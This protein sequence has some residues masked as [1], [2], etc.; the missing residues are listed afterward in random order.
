MGSIAAAC[1]TASQALGL[2]I[3][4]LTLAI[5]VEKIW[6]YDTLG[7]QIAS[8]GTAPDSASLVDLQLGLRKK[9]HYNRI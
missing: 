2:A 1:A 7:Q 5:A 3:V 4:V 8:L 6:K 9:Q